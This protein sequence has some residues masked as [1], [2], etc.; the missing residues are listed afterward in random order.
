MYALPPYIPLD[1]YRRCTYRRSLPHSRPS[2]SALLLSSAHTASP[3]SWWG[4]GLLASRLFLVFALKS[5]LLILSL[6]NWTSI[7]LRLFYSVLLS[8]CSTTPNRRLSLGE[9]RGGEKRMPL[10]SPKDTKVYQVGSTRG[11]QQ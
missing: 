6:L 4:I 2:L 3:F 11:H 9:R 10:Y 1:S 8:M 5:Y 7:S